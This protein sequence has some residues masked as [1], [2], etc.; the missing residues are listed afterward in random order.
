MQY[1]LVGSPTVES[2]NENL[3]RLFV[4]DQN[5]A[6]VANAHVKVWAGPPP[7]GLPPYFV[8]DVPFRLTSPSGMLEYFAVV[9]PMPDTRD[10]W[11]QVEAGDGTAQ[12]DPVQ[13]HFP[14]GSTI[15]IMATLQGGNGTGTGGTP[16]PGTVQWDPRLTAMHVSIAPVA[17]LAPGQA[18]WKIIS[19][20]YQDETQ[21]G[22]NHNVYYTVLDEKGFP[23]PGVPVRLDWQGR[24]PNDVPDTVYTDGNGTANYG[25][26]HGQQ[27]WDPNAGPGPYTA[28][29]GDPDLRGNR[30]TT[31]P[32]EKL[33]GAGLPM[34]RHVNFVV[35]WRKIT[36]AV[37][38]PANSSLH[39]TLQNAPAN[40][41]LT[42][43]SGTQTFHTNAGPSGA[44]SFSNL[45]AGTYALAI[46]GI[47]VVN[48]NI[49]LDGTNSVT[50]NYTVAL[51]P[52]TQVL[53]H[54]LLFGAPSSSAAQTNLVLA[55]DYIL[56]F[57]PTVGFSLNEARSAKNVTV[58]G[59]NVLSTQD[60]ENLKAAGCVVRHIAGAD[61]YA[62]QQLF[63]QLVASGNPY[64]GT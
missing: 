10:Y 26:Y 6:P 27:G 40:A 35:T 41:L 38:A 31:I 29:V 20:Q 4:R 42:L 63:A 2:H 13:F 33:A 48:P 58:V 60:E 30:P 25:L 62:V 37:A 39:G 28:W 24:D 16:V 51:Q 45:P 17:N 52:P 15:W 36:S 56:R 55:L 32:G 7:T 43:T 50:F 59:A 18:Y 49:V 53:T 21:S 5:G 1:H 23:A 46:L 9:G 47:G 54:Y 8:D 57:T 3:M 11:M 19:A 22:G 34:N 64:P 44:Y 61:S 14:Q 12:S